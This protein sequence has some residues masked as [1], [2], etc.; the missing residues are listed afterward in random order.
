MGGGKTAW[1]VRI[2]FPNMSKHTV[3]RLAARR[4]HVRAGSWA[5]KTVI[6]ARPVTLVPVTC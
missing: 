2:G 4:G 3:D 1:L 6:L 5:A